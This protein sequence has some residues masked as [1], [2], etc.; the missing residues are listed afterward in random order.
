MMPKGAVSLAS[1]RANPVTAARTAFDRMRPS[2]G[3]LAAIEVTLRMRPKRR[4]FMPGRTARVISITEQQGQAHGGQPGRLVVAL[5]GAGGRSAR[6]GDEDVHAPV[7]ADR[8]LRDAPG[9]ARLRDVGGR[10][11]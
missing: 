7:L 5:E 8:L 6:V 10:P 1:V 3:C 2:T 9:I 11:R 4:S